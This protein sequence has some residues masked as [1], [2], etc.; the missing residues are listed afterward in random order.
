[1]KEEQWYC[2]GMASHRGSAVYLPTQVLTTISRDETRDKSGCHCPCLRLQV[3]H[4][5][6]TGGTEWF[7]LS[8]FF[9]LL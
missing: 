5:L 2:T 1:M 7:T 8:R 3:N 9:R 4:C 6:A